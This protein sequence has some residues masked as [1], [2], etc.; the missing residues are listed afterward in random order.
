MEPRISHV[1][2]F[3]SFLVDIVVDKPTTLEL[4]VSIGDGD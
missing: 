1:P 2:R 3:V 4:S